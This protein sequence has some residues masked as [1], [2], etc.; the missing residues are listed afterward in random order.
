MEEL[1]NAAKNPRR[2]SRFN[3]LLAEDVPPAQQQQQQQDVAG[4]A[5]ESGRPMSLVA[6]ELAP[7]AENTSANLLHYSGW[8]DWCPPSGCHACWSKPAEDSV[9]SVLVS[10]F[11]YI[12]Q[13]RVV[14]R[15]AGILGH[16]ADQ[17]RYQGLADGAALAF[18]KA[19]FNPEKAT[20]EEPGRTCAEYL[21]PQ[22]TISLAAELGVIPAEHEAA[23]IQTLVD[24]IAS[25]DW[26][27]NVGIVRRLFNSLARL[28]YSAY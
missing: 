8:S 21:S 2:N 17:S 11:Y 16:T 24:D 23:V 10:S 4:A 25:H 9:N 7:H 13:L 20:Y 22:T 3:D 19:F 27:L 15:Y 1:I 5:G 28:L 14:A 12:S 26:H 6:N 18:N